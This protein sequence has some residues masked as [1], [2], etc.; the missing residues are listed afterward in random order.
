MAFK[1]DSVIP[2]LTISNFIVWQKGKRFK[3]L[4]WLRMTIAAISIYSMIIPVALLDLFLWQYQNTYFRLL[5]IPR[6]KRS[7]YVIMDRYDLAG[8]SVFQRFDCLYCEYVNGVIAYAKDVANQTEVY[9]CAIKHR[10]KGKG[11]EHQKDFYPQ[12]KF[13]TRT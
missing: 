3:R 13:D 12:S 5:G 9:S 7:E 4:D 10:V 6:I 8:L 11:Q 2:D 1:L